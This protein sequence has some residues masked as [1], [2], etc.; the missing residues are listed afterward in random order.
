MKK[1]IVIAL[2]AC[3]ALLAACGEKGPNLDSL[4]VHSV[5]RTGDQA[6]KAEVSFDQ[7]YENVFAI[8]TSDMNN[9]TF[10]GEAFYG[11]ELGKVEPGKMYTIEVKDDDSWDFT[12]IQKQVRVDK[13]GPHDVPPDMKT[14]VIKIVVQDSGNV[15]LEA[16][17]APIEETEAESEDAAA[18][19]S[20]N[21]TETEAQ[22]A[23]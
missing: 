17:V 13:Y 10:E 4:A 9:H 22:A 8:F 15:L 5:E 11:Y 12:G 16:E 18:S 20:K 7:E 6:A 19:E 3:V 23:E 21:E 1:V 14:E 2:L